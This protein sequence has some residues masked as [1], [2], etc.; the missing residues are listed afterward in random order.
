MAASR[1]IERAR[2][3]TLENLTLA[4]RCNLSARH[5]DGGKERL[6]VRVQRIGIEPLLWRNLDDLAEVHDRNPVADVADDGEIVRD[7]KIGQPQ[8]RTELIEQV[9]DLRL[10][11][12]IQHRLVASDEIRLDRERARNADALTLAAGKFVGKTAGYA[13]TEPDEAEQ[14]RHGRLLFGGEQRTQAP[15]DVVPLNRV[16]VLDPLENTIGA[17]RTLGKSRCGTTLSKKFERG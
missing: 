5:R 6:R 10:Y 15:D 13:R 8:A 11:R 2:N 17:M 4:L 12:N 14:C 1:R 7:E 9:D 16:V 3:L